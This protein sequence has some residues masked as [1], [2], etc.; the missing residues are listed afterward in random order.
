MEREDLRQKLLYRSPTATPSPR[1]RSSRP[2]SART[3]SGGTPGFVPMPPSR[4]TSARR[5]HRNIEADADQVQDIPDPL[6]IPLPRYVR[7]SHRANP[8]DIHQIHQIYEPKQR[9][10]RQRPGC[11]SAPAGIAIAR[12]QAVRLGG[13][14]AATLDPLGLFPISGF[15]SVFCLVIYFGLQPFCHKVF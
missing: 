6:C 12:G 15:R 14:D 11:R 13:Q 9:S 7:R 1:N 2:S 5:P 4:P 10:P 3:F 8:A